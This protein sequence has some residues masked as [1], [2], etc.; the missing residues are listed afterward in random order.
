MTIEK[1]KYTAHTLKFVKPFK[2]SKGEISSRRIIIV[3]AETDCGNIVYGEIAPLDGFSAESFEEALNEVETICSSFRSAG[4]SD[5]NSIV[6]SVKN[7]SVKFGLE[8]I[9]AGLSALKSGAAP[10][11]I[12]VK[13]NH[14]FTL[15]DLLKVDLKKYRD[16]TIKIKLGIGDSEDEIIKLNGIGAALSDENIFLR[17]DVNCGWSIDKALSLIDKIELNNIEYIEQPVA[18]TSQLIQLAGE[19]PFPIAADESLYQSH[20]L[21]MILNSE[22]KHLIVKPGIFGGLNSI[23]NL[24]LEKSPLKKITIS[25]ALES[26]LGWSYLLFIADKIDPDRRHGLGTF[27]LFKKEPI[28]VELTS[29]DNWVRVKYP[30]NIGKL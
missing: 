26:N 14:V 25:S 17:L 10:T 5:F 30:Q 9:S 12:E 8:Q 23:K 6:H 24:I 28:K 22:V 2:S 13:I 21:N 15:A 27:N 1:I 3:E 18:D 4:I 29:A 7:P 16:S 19:S 20:S 11:E